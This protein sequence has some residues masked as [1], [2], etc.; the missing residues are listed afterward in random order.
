MSQAFLKEHPFFEASFLHLPQLL[1]EV[2]EWQLFLIKLILEEG[3]A[4][5]SSLEATEQFK[6]LL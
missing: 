3:D 4:V 1:H 6:E 2:L 5:F